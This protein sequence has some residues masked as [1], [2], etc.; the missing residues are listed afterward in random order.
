[1]KLIVKLL[2][3]LTVPLMLVA[4]LASYATYLRGGDPLALF[5]QATASAG[6]RSGHW[7]DEIKQFA[8]GSAASLRTTLTP[9]DS[10]GSARATT[11]YRWTDADGSP[12]YSNVRPVGVGQVETVSVAADRN[13]FSTNNGTNP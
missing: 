7:L 12:H 3:R 6:E 4:G 9:A 8:V 13:L 11:L 10:A 5:Q 2:F 1:M